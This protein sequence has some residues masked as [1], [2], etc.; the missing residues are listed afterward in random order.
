MLE[1]LE[2]PADKDND[3]PN[4]LLVSRDLESDDNDSKSPISEAYKLVKD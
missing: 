3:D 4:L 1:L 2:V